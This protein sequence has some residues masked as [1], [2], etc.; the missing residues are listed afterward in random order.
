VDGTKFRELTGVSK[1]RVN[2][3]HHQAPKKLGKGLRP[4]AFAPDGVM[5]A[6]EAEGD[7]LLFGVEWHP[8]LL[9]D[10]T[11]RR[12]FGALVDAARRALRAR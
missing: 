6:F 10:E 9:A 2:S 7:R 8:E 4:A 12:L 11:T 5:E 3:A 1:I